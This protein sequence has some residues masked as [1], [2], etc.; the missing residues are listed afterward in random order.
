MPQTTKLRGA[1]LLKVV[2]VIMI[3]FGAISIGSGFISMA[4][5]SAMSSMFGLDEYARQYFWMLGIIAVITGAVELVIGIFGVRFGNRAEKTNFLLIAGI[6]QIVVAVFTTLYNSTI[7]PMGLRVYD[8]IMEA[9]V[10]MYG[11]MPA[12][13]NL[14]A[15]SLSGS[16]TLNLIGFILPVLFIIGALLNRLPPKQIGPAMAAGPQAGALPEQ[17]PLPGVDPYTQPQEGYAF[18]QPQEGDAFAQP[19]EEEAGQD[20]TPQEDEQDAEPETP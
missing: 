14:N 7:A 17:Q 12:T 2:G 9:T 10:Q 16:P 15:T 3:I 11:A 13:A 19:P 5:G 18:A 6:V 8:Q 4:S 1:A 20:A